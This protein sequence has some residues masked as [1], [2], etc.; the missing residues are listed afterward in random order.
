MK[1][2][3]VDF[4]KRDFRPV[5]HVPE[6]TIDRIVVNSGITQRNL[7]DMGDGYDGS[8]VEDLRSYQHN[9]AR[10]LVIYLEKKRQKHMGDNYR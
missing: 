7:R 4:K 6:Q 2:R 5:P 3:I 9:V 8:T 1:K 10:E